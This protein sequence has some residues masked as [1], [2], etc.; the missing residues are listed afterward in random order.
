MARAALALAA[1]LVLLPPGGAAAEPSPSDRFQ[2]TR[3]HWRPFR[4]SYDAWFS[5][6]R[7][8]PRYLRAAGESVVLVGIGTA[9]YWVDPLANRTDWD[10]PTLGAK[11]RFEAVSPFVSPTAE[12]VGSPEVKWAML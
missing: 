8:E 7:R 10:F 1:L 5:A 6:V 11:L 9:Y 2:D 4:E 12:S 3:G